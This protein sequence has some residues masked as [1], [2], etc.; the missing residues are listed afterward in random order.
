MPILRAGFPLYDWIG[1]YASTGPATADRQTLFELANMLA[2]GRH[3][4][5]HPYHSQLSQKRDGLP[6]EAIL[7]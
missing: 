2:E 4:Q 1:G 7:Q 3:H 6:R 5:I